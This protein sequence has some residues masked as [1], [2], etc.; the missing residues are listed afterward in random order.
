MDIGHSMNLKL[1]Q[2]LTPSKPSSAEWEIPQLYTQKHLRFRSLQE[3]RENAHRLSQGCPNPARAELGLNEIFINAIEHGNL[4]ITYND[5]IMF[6]DAFE[7]FN[8]VNKRL[9][10]RENLPKF[11]QV[12]VEATPEL[13]KFTVKD[14][15][16]GFDWNDYGSVDKIHR[17]NKSG[18]GILLAREMGFDELNYSSPGNQVEGI[19]YRA[20]P[21]HFPS[22]S[23]R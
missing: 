12:I 18:R 5:K 11:V 2:P 17:L 15:G 14:Q 1:V 9:M 6:K 3:A 13:I 20:L 10:M 22:S 8:E 7:W 19:I 21:T 16:L 23:L 4:G